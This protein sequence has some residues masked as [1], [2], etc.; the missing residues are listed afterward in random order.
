MPFFVNPF[1]HQ[2]QVDIINDLAKGAEKSKAIA[3]AIENGRIKVNFLTDELFEREVLK[4]NPNFRGNLK[5]ILGMNFQDEI[6]Y[7]YIQNGNN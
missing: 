7:T 2:S 5:N 6:F 3:K 4:Y 1:M